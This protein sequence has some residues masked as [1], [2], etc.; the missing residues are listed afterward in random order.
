M[1][2][3]SAWNNHLSSSGKVEYSTPWPLFRQLDDLI[4]PFSLDAA[5][6][7]ENAK[8][9]NFITKEENS[10]TVDWSSRSPN[11]KVWLNPPYDRDLHLWLAKAY[12]QSR[13]GV[14]TAVLVFVRP[15]TRWWR[16]RAM[17]AS[18]IIFITGRVKFGG[19]T[20]NAP[21]PSCV[22]VY[23]PHTAHKGAIRVS[24]L[25]QSKEA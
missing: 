8:C 5:A 19:S 15:D 12:E 14:T 24:L 2:S 25:A 23:R 18:Q 17:K 6:S 22:L 21:Y 9:A 3:A 16:D 20:T 1:K 7:A 11:K 10:L 13:K 4:G